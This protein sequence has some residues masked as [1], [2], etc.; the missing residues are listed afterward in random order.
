MGE[1]RQ[2]GILRSNPSLTLLPSD[3]LSLSCVQGVLDH[4]FAGGTNEHPVPADLLVT[5]TVPAG[6]GLSS[7]AA[8]VVASS[9]AFLAVNGKVCRCTLSSDRPV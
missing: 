1:L 7:S 6:S 8:M 9:L 5:G 3:R 2:S 4:F